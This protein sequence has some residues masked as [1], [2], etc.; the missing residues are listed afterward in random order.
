MDE[1]NKTIEHWA[2]EDKIADWVLAAA[3]AFNGWRAIGLKVSHD[4]FK[5]GIAAALEV[6]FA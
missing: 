6:K 3:R 4:E 1:D 5:N 2:V